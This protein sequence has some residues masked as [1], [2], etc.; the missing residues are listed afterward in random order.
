MSNGSLELSNINFNI[1]NNNTNNTNNIKKLRKIEKLENDIFSLER[2][3]SSIPT[4]LHNDSNIDRIKTQ[5]NL[6]KSY[7]SYET[8]PTISKKYN[9]IIN[10]LNEDLK[11]AELNKKKHYNNRKN[12]TVKIQKLRN[13]LRNVPDKVNEIR[14]GGNMRILKD[15]KH[16]KTHKRHTHKRRNTK[17]NRN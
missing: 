9:T 10:N 11:Q 16:R 7:K 8:R 17:R 12:I 6:Y 3:Y 15:R 2:N 5:I 1:I 13:E 14:Y 4:Q